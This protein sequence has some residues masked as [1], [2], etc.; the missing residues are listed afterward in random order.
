MKPILRFKTIS[1]ER[2]F[3]WL[4]PGQFGIAFIITVVV[5]TAAMCKNGLNVSGFFST[6]DQWQRGFW[7]ASLMVFTMQMLLILVFGYSIAISPKM[8]R[9][10]KA[11]AELPQSGGQAVVIATVISM[12]ASWLNWGL[13]LVAGAIFVRLAGHSLQSR[14]NPFNYPLLGAS[15]YSGMMIWHGG[16]SGSAPLKAAEPGHLKSMVPSDIPVP[17]TIE[18]TS[19]L[20]SGSTLLITLFTCLAVV[21]TSIF[22]YRLGYV[23]NHNSEIPPLIAESAPNADSVTGAERLEFNKWPAYLISLLIFGFLIHK[24]IH[25]KSL[26]FFTPNVV[27]SIL[28]GTGLWLHGSLRAY[29]LSIDR[30]MTSAAGVVLLFPFYFGIIGL[31][32]YSGL[33]TEIT[34][35]FVA[36]AGVGTFPLLVFVSSALLN[37]LIPSGGGQWAVQGPIIL[38]SG[39][40]LGIPL[41]NVIMSF[42]YGDQ[43]TNM[44]QPFWA[45][46]LLYITRIKASELLGY[47]FFIFLA[48]LLIFSLGILLLF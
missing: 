31:L 19:T 15:G 44:L 23:N 17:D 1:G 9:I 8:Y 47:T 22:L 18:I 27:I 32:R 2:F 29:M 28:L 46:P 5:M 20:L 25:E 35:W 12:V 38:E 33:T 7:D 30:A 34:G 14:K 6:L 4:I 13:G 26:G 16:L 42:V 36:H 40:R 11:I 37:L 39:L 43:L 10:L 41:E 24:G 3:R 45:I 48:G 21:A